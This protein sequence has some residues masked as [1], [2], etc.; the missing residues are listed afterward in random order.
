MTHFCLLLKVGPYTAVRDRRSNQRLLIAKWLK[1]SGI[2]VLLPHGLDGAGP[3]HSSMRIERFLQVSSRSGTNANIVTERLLYS[4]AKLT[5]DSY[6]FPASGVAQNVNMHVVFPTTP[7]QY[8]HLLRRQMKRNFRKPLIVAA[9][10][11]LL[12][13]PV[14]LRGFL[15]VARFADRDYLSPLLLANKGRL[16]AT[17]RLRARVTIQTCARRVPQ[18]FTRTRGEGYFFRGKSHSFDR[19]TVL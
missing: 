10:K 3:E 12:R 11:G 18:R 17:V 9:P 4:L 7:T 6:D 15:T 13:L 16:L 14:S 1:Q 5:N 2:V 8:F 19:K